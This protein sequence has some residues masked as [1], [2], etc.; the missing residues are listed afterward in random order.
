MTFHSQFPFVQVIFLLYSYTLYSCTI[1]WVPLTISL[2]NDVDGLFIAGQY[3]QTQLHSWPVDIYKLFAL[4][5]FGIFSQF[6]Q[7]KFLF[8]QHTTF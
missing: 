3:I 1:L 8:L 4:D 5:S 6:E 7:G 2:L